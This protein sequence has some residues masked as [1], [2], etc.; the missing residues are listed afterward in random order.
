MSFIIGRLESADV[1]LRSLQPAREFLLR[2]PGLLTQGG[3]LQRH[4][5]RFARLFKARSERRWRATIPNS[6]AQNRRVEL[7]RQ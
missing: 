5:P 6:A 7:S 3:E 4:I 2:K 1:L